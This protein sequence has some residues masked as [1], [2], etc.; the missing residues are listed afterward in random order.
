MFAT[1]NGTSPQWLND[2]ERIGEYYVSLSVSSIAE[3]GRQRSVFASAD[4]T[5][6]KRVCNFSDQFFCHQI[7]PYGNKYIVTYSLGSGLKFGYYELDDIAQIL[8][9]NALSTSSHS[10]DSSVFGPQTLNTNLP[11]E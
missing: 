7:V 8:D 9:P 11:L 3:N 1:W 2:L 10:V 5:A 4:G 6:W